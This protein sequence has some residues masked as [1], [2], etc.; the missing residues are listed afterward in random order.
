MVERFPTQTVLQLLN[1]FQPSAIRFSHRI[2]CNRNLRMEKVRAIGLD[3]DYT[4]AIYRTAF[5]RLAFNEALKRLVEKYEFPREALSFTYDP[6][7]AIRGLV[8]DMKHGNIFKMDRH[9][10]VGRAFH[11]TRSMSSE[12][13]VELYRKKPIHLSRPYY[14]LVD[15]LFTLPETHMYAQ[16]VDLLDRTGKGDARHYERS[17]RAIR[18]AVDEIHKDGTLKGHVKDHL[19]DYVV[20]DAGTAYTLER[21]KTSGKRCFLLTNSEWEYTDC[22]M[23]YLL[24][25]VLENFPR[26]TDYFHT[27]IASANKPAFFSQTAPPA[28]EKAAP[29]DAASKIFRGGSLRH[30]EERLEASGDQ[31]LYIGDHIYGDILKSK[32]TSA[33]RTTMII[34]EME[35]ELE[36]LEASREELLRFDRLFGRREQAN[37]ELNYQQRLLQSILDLQQMAGNGHSLGEVD[38][39][40]LVASVSEQNVTQV[41]KTLDR[42]DDE[43]LT[44]IRA[45]QARFNP[46]WGMLFK[47]GSV[48]SVFGEQTETYACTYTSRFSNFLAYSPVHYFRTPRDVLPHEREV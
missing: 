9:R 25:G 6:E 24:D 16:M 33:W 43:I 48:H 46:R 36:G 35:T 13:R 44:T 1:L 47:E 15:T 31:I 19:A 38:P 29:E 10:H 40:R 37:I 27:I 39:M 5:D 14:F 2:F 20:R 30:L 32:K 41:K 28:Q 21:F 42:M 8:I 11:G 22:V 7:F 18:T 23:S 3:M 12:K 4:L 34:P 26:W 17:Y 45:T